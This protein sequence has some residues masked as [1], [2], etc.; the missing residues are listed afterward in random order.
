MTSLAPMLYVDWNQ[1]IRAISGLLGGAGLDQ[2]LS[3][4]AGG[5]PAEAPKGQEP[6]AA[7]RNSLGDFMNLFLGQ[8]TDLL[9]S[10]MEMT[11]AHEIAHQWWAIGVGSDSIREPFVD[12]S[13]A[14][15]SAVLYFEERYGRAAAEKIINMHLKMPYSVGRMLGGADVP[16][17]LPTA[18]YAGSLQS[19][20]VVYGKGALYYDALRRAVGDAVFS[21]SLREYYATYRGKLVGPR[22]LLEIV[23]AKAPSAGVA[24]LYR[25]WIEEAHGDEDISGGPVIGLQDLLSGFLRQLAGPETTSPK[26]PVP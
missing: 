24:D 18:A 22:A 26:K 25:H 1:Q 5:K 19:G 10:L 15:Y 7:G 13:L 23:Q 3:G 14:N 6:Q 16:A 20:A 21:S 17:N 8:Q 4:L 11:V 2:M 12:E 9:G